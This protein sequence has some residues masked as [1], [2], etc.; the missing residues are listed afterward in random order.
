LSRNGVAFDAAVEIDPFS[1]LPKWQQP[2][3]TA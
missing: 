2:R 1:L 3:K